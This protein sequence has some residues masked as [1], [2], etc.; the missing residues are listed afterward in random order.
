MTFILNFCTLVDLN[1]DFFCS[2]YFETFKQYFRIFK[3]TNYM[4]L[5]LHLSKLIRTVLF[6][7]LWQQDILPTDGAII[8]TDLSSV[9]PLVYIAAGHEILTSFPTDRSIL[10]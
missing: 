2:N 9:V 7:E 6:L 4:E 8:N 10:Q 1:Q 3:K 5:E